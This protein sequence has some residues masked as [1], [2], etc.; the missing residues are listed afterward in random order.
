MDCA[1]VVLYNY[2]TQENGRSCQNQHSRAPRAAPTTR[3]SVV[4]RPGGGAVRHSGHAGAALWQ[5]GLPMPGRGAARALSVCG[6]AQAPGERPPALCP[7]R[8]G[9]SGAPSNCGNHAG[10]GG[11][12][13]DFRD[14]SGVVEPPQAGL[15]DGAGGGGVAGA[16]DGGGQHGRSRARRGGGR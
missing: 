2:C 7:G 16:S 13:R 9:R 6:A 10:R 4:G 3:E 1:R 14:Q 5:A 15:N 12:G 11:V 8:A